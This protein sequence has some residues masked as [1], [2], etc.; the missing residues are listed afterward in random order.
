MP[1][2]SPLTPVDV[3]DVD[4][5][6]FLLEGASARG[7]RPAYVDG[8][9]GRTLSF[10]ALGAAAHRFAAGLAARGFGRGDVL[11]VLAPNLPEWPVAM[12]GAQLAGGAITPVN[13]LWTPEEIAAQL[14][15]SRARAVVTVGPFVAA[16]RAAAPGLE[17]VVVGEAPAGTT[18]FAALVST[19]APPPD[20]RIDPATDVAVLPFS[21]GTTGL[22]KGVRLTHRNLV[23]N[24]VQTRAVLTPAPDDVMI[25]LLPFFHAAGFCSSIC[26]TLRAGATVVTLPRF[27]LEA[28]LRLVEAHRA[29]LLPAAPPVVLGLARSPAVDRYDVSSLELVIC[30]SAPLP[31]A[32]ESECAR[33]LGCTV[34]QVYGLTETSPVL[35]ISRRDGA[36]HTPGA[37]GTLVPSTEV[38]LVDP[39]TGAEVPAGTT[40]ELHVRGP[41]VMAGY[42]DD[43]PATAAAIDAEGWFR[44]GDLGTVTA[45]GEVVVVDRVKE[46]IKVSGF[47]VAPAELEA[48]LVTHPAVADAAVVGRPDERTGER[49]VAYVVARGPLDPAEVIGW[50]AERTAG[51]K[52]LAEVVVVEAVPRSP[53]GKVLRRVLRDRAAAP[54]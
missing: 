43:P 53:A 17:V 27:D 15:G 21:S 36:G 5:P 23:A 42:L 40:G 6:T 25:G 13:P 4:L 10:A 47:Q 12:L 2:H 52:R 39:L 38:R 28:C 19:T 45:D 50:A 14:R 46:L 49:P 7:T 24:V 44:T 35:S 29:T 48:L 32:L 34:G 37:V 1:L 18:P 8:P 9:T 16:A 30:G 3:P 22:P 11:A 54:V 31:G 20:V 51:Y 26:L 33:R 41:Q